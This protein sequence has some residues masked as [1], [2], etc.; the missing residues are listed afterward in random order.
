MDFSLDAVVFT[1][2]FTPQDP[3]SIT[4]RRLTTGGSSEEP[5]PKNHCCGCRL[6]ISTIFAFFKPTIMI[7]TLRLLLHPL[8]TDQ[9][10]AY[11][12]CDG[13]L[14]QE[15]K[16]QRSQGPVSPELE[17]AL[18]LTILPAVKAAAGH[19]YF[20]TL[21]TLIEK[22]SQKMVGDLCFMGEPGQ[23]GELM[24]GYGLYDH[25]R[26][27]GFMTEAVGGI[28]GWALSQ[29]GVKAVV[30]ET[31]PANEASWRVLQRNGFVRVNSDGG[32]WLWRVS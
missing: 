28:V 21:W 7:E 6:K 22:S 15:L 32:L 18:Q 2:C 29:P 20:S 19:C 10:I 12:R 3:D 23:S 16:I 13:S 5:V 31:D 14:E 17:E 27:Q 26:G 4:T 1:G 11:T 9:L 24:L 30:A 8:T 25:C